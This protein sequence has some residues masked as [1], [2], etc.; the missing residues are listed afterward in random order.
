MGLAKNKM[1]GKAKP[2]YPTLQK[3]IDQGTLLKV[4]VAY[5]ES[6][7]ISE[8]EIAHHAALLALLRQGHLVLRKELVEDPLLASLIDEELVLPKY[9]ET[10]DVLINQIHRLLSLP[11]KQR[12]ISEVKF[13]TDEQNQALQ[14]ALTHPISLIT[15]GPGTGK[16]YTAQKIVE[17]LKQSTILTAPTGKAATNLEKNIDFPAV[18]KTLHSLL[19]IRSPLDYQ[20]EVDLLEAELVI[21][22]ECSMIDPFLFARLLSAIGPNTHILLMGDVNQL[23]AVEGGSVFADLIDAAILP[24]TSLSKCMRSDRKEI[25]QL[26]QNILTN[27]IKD[28]R[29]INLGFGENDLEKIYAN[30][31]SYVKDRDF[32][33][34][35]ILS[36]LRKGPLG[37]DALNRFLYDKFSAISDQFPIMIRR[38]DPKTGLANGDTGM[39]TQNKA[40][41]NNREF[42]LAELPSFEYAYC[43]SVHKSQGSEYDHVLFLIPEGSDNFGKEVIYTAVTRA[44]HKLDIDGKSEQIKKALSR[45]SRKISTLLGRLRS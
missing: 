31:W 14:N 42:A 17:T 19:G 4:D 35:R 21:V 27:E 18:C 7:A 2:R 25:L 3:L 16:T 41:I 20:N 22:D 37:V 5:G 12:E 24:T 9:L 10:E 30:L 29:T 26:A 15:G 13:L 34:F 36:T 33:S 40:T 45:S 6:Q 39:I 1:F 32:E 23:P 8:K 11:E 44:K 38:N 43:I 28:I